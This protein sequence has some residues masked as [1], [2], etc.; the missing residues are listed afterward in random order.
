MPVFSTITLMNVQTT[1]APIIS[2]SAQLVVD[3]PQTGGKRLLRFNDNSL[4]HVGLQRFGGAPEPGG[5]I[6]GRCFSYRFL[7]GDPV[8]VLLRVSRSLKGKSTARTALMKC[9]PGE[10]Q[11]TIK[12]RYG[13]QALTILAAPMQRL[14][15]GEA[16]EMLGALYNPALDYKDADAVHFGLRFT[17]MT[18]NVQTREVHTTGEH[19]EQTTVHLKRKPRRITGI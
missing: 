11:G 8:Y 9:A 1:T 19:G 3:D 5:R 17:G 7:R 4:R 14:N 16:R 13:S 18:P 10:E 6:P 2:T 15:V 12:M